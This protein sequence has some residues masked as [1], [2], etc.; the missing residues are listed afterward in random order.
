MTN[1][2]HETLVE[3]IG[4]SK[5]S[6]FSVHCKRPRGTVDME[7]HFFIECETVNGY[8]AEQ[9]FNDRYTEVKIY[10]QK[11]SSSPGFEIDGEYFSVGSFTNVLIGQYKQ[12]NPGTCHGSRLL[13]PSTLDLLLASHLPERVKKAIRKGEKDIKRHEKYLKELKARKKQLQ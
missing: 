3:K 8:L 9:G 11:T 7:G 2:Q 1:E 5:T 12:Y 10:Q 6:C 13:D 4:S